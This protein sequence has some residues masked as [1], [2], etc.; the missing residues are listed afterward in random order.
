[1]SNLYYDCLDHKRK[2]YALRKTKVYPWFKS[3]GFT[4]PYEQNRGCGPIYVGA[5]VFSDQQRHEYYDAMR[6]YV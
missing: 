2:Q 4:L 1:M 3:A 6:A 5:Y